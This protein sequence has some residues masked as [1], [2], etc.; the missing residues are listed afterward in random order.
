[1]AQRG[2]LVDPRG[3]ALET[4]AWVGIRDGKGKPVLVE[5]G[6]NYRDRTLDPLYSL[7]REDP[8]TLHGWR[9]MWFGRSQRQGRRYKASF[10]LPA[11]G[12]K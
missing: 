2:G 8:H 10:Q 6:G 9:H 12:E 7:K 4:A 5:A 11:I 1:M 3:L